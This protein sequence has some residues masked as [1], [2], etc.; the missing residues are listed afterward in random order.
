[1]PYPKGSK[2]SIGVVCDADV[3]AKRTIRLQTLDGAKKMV[4]ISEALAM[5][6]RSRDLKRFLKLYESHETSQRLLIG[7]TVQ[8]MKMRAWICKRDPKARFCK[9]PKSSVRCLPSGFTKEGIHCGPLR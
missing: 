6:R 2:Q 4:K 9:K 3:G 5:I 7:V 8:A 1:M